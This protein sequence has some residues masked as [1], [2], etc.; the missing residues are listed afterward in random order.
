M[1]NICN[2]PKFIFLMLTCTIT[3]FFYS[4]EKGVWDLKRSNP[5]DSQYSGLNSKNDI[6]PTLTTLNVTNIN[7]TSA[8]SGGNISSDGGSAISARGVCWSSSPSPKV[9]DS[10]TSDAQGIGNFS[11]NITGLQSN[12]T[13]YVRAYATN[14]LG[15][16]Y[17]DEVSFKTVSQVSLPTLSTITV[18]SIYSSVAS[19]GGNITNDGGSSITSRGV[20][21]GISP[22]PTVNNSK[23][24]DGSGIGVFSSS[25]IGL[26]AN[27]L[28][29]VRSYATNT[30]GT[31]YGNEVTFST[32]T[33]SA[34]FNNELNKVQFLNNSV[35]YSCGNGIILK[36]SDGG[37]QWVSVKESTSVNF[38]SI[39]FTSTDVGF[40]GGN[41][42][43]YAY[44]YKTTNGGLTW[45]EVGKFWFSNERTKVTAIFSSLD[46]NKITALVNQYP[47]ANQVNG[48]MYFSNNSGSAWTSAQG[49][50]NSG[51]DSGDIYNQKIYAGGHQYWTGTIYETSVFDNSFISTSSTSINKNLVDKAVNLNAIDIVSNYGFAVGD[52]GQF[53]ITTDEG[54]NWTSKT[55]PGFSTSSFTSIK[56]K[57]N[58]TGWI[59][60]L[61]GL[62]L[63]TTDSGLTWTTIFNASKKIND[64]SIR[65]DGKL[66]IAGE[67]G[68][69]KS[70]N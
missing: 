16:G 19:S 29:Y 53:L 15:T 37:N 60:T 34:T 43:Y 10:K 33:A 56:F 14:S 65:S 32:T 62:V 12:T 30:N 51:F 41:D 64:I 61:S 54:K 24:T 21:W 6:L 67:L 48:W 45:Q 25:L 1:K 28:Y 42:Q 31:S 36:T 20:C 46:G 63:Q 66:F 17:G 38:T 9:S 47:N 40:V 44:V 13:Y 57:D 5:N 2:F 3:L 69:I 18:S 27:T 49:Y 26:S 50:K 39:Y 22:S 55:I 58:S 35:G 23:T 68:L 70:V 59:S 4:C 52:N 8:F 7:T 11:S